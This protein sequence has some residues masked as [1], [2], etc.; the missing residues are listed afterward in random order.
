[1]MAVLLFSV[2]I[3]WATLVIIFAVSVVY[4]LTQKKYVTLSSFAKSIHSVN[5]LIIITL[6]VILVKNRNYN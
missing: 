6:I 4:D 1:M 3:E 5:S 2:F